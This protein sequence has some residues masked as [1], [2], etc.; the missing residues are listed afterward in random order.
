M[1]LLTLRQHG[2]A[3]GSGVTYFLDGGIHYVSI[4]AYEPHPRSPILCNVLSLSTSGQLRRWK[5]GGRGLQNTSE[6][7]LLCGNVER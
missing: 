6:R 7:I 1:I 2:Q 3:E 4:Y 5:N